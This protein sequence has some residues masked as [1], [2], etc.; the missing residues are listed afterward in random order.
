MLTALTFP[1]QVTGRTRVTPFPTYQLVS[2]LGGCRWRWWQVYQLEAEARRHVEDASVT[3]ELAVDD[4]A[5]ARIGDHLEA[6][7]AR[8]RRHVDGGTI[9]A[10]AVFRRLDHGVGLGV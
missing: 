6:A 2:G 3:V 5:N 10:D 9:D 4:A 1:G 8:R 7:P